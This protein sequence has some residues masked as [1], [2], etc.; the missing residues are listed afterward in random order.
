MSGPR[1]YAGGCHCGRVR[2]EATAELTKVYSCNCS[3]C[4]KKAPMLAFIPATHFEVLTGEE[5]LTEYQFNKM[6]VHHLFCKV[7]GVQ[8][9]AWALGKDGEKMYAINVRCLD[10]VDLEGLP[11]T[12]VDGKKL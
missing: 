4:S 6:N 5:C 2:Y 1:A 8:S 7:C 11:E 3:I 12:K 10:D 9:F